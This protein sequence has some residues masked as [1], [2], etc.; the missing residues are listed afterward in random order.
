MIL[1]FL[2]SPIKVQLGGIYNQQLGY[3]NPYQI[4]GVSGANALVNSLPYLTNQFNASDLQSGL[5]PNYQFML[6]QGLGATRQSQNVTGGGSNMTR[7]ADMFAQNYAGNAYQ[8]AF[9]N[10]QTQRQDI[11]GN[12]ASLA[13]IGQSGS[14]ALANLQGYAPGRT[15]G[16]PEHPE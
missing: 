1:L 3:Q 7:A 9:N 8:Q 5:A 11:Y 14:N 4:T 16:A 15:H 12:L 2:P 10:Y 6:G 13:G